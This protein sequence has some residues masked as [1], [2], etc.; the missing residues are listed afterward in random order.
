LLI[1]NVSALGPAD[2]AALLRATL[3]ELKATA[4]TESDA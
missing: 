4:P 2:A 3:A 1:S